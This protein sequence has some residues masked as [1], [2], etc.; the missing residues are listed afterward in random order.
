MGLTDDTCMEFTLKKGEAKSFKASKGQTVKITCKNGGQMAD[1]VFPTYHQGLTLDN[2]RRFVLKKGDLLYDASEEAVLEVLSII[3]DAETNILFPGCRR[4]FYEREYNKRKDGCR[5]ILASALGIPQ[6]QLPS[7]INLFMDFKLN[8]IECGFDVDVSRAKDGDYVI[9]SVKKDC[10][11]AVSACPCE[12]DS[13]RTIGNI[14]V[15]VR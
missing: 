6:T 5:E 8:P 14:I 1:I 7:T 4:R 12:L 9:F 11:I 3:S 2:L 13:C 15:D 10:T